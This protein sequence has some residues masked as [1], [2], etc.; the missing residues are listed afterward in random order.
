M[1]SI[2]FMLPPMRGDDLVGLPATDDSTTSPDGLPRWPYEPGAFYKRELPFLLQV[3]RAAAAP[4]E[5][6]VI[7]GVAKEVEAE[8]RASPTARAMPSCV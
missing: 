6:V 3:L 7:D 4:I 1:C 8:R 2:A 5:T